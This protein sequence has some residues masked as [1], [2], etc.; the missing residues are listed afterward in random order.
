MM[1]DLVLLLVKDTPEPILRYL[2]SR[3]REL[4]LSVHRLAEGDEHHRILL[5]AP[6]AVLEAQAAQMKIEMS[7]APTATRTW[8]ENLY[9]V[10]TFSMADRASFCT[11]DHT[12]FGVVEFEPAQRAMLLHA[13]LDSKLLSDDKNWSAALAAA[14]LD[15]NAAQVLLALEQLGMIEEAWP[16][17]TYGRYESLGIPL[18]ES[19]AVAWSAYARGLASRSLQLVEPDRIRAYWGEGVGFYFAWQL[20]YLRSL[21]VPALCGLLVWLWRYGIACRTV[22]SSVPAPLCASLLCCMFHALAWS[23]APSRV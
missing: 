11:A 19:G 2:E 20:F 6:L 16:A 15:S 9:A 1:I 10:R 4:K 23:F 21:L 17:H 8:S 18:R 22:H 5:H 7:L 14:G 13:Y 12:S 3:L